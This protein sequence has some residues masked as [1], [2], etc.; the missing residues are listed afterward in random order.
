MSKSSENVCVYEEYGG[1]H[2]GRVITIERDD[3]VEYRLM[4]IGGIAV[5]PTNEDAEWV[6]DALVENGYEWTT[7]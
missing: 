6:I 1:P 4:N 5:V 2:V 3:E 7:D